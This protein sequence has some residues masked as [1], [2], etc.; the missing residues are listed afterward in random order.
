VRYEDL[1]PGDLID[2]HVLV[3]DHIGWE[4]ERREVVSVDGQTVRLRDGE[5]EYEIDAGQDCNRALRRRAH[6]A[7]GGR[8]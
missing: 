6:A 7:T 2:V 4:W 8:R 1:R 3:A 5:R